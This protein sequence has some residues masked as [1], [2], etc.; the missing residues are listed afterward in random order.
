MAWKEGIE[1]TLSSGFELLAIPY[2]SSWLIWCDRNFDNL[3]LDIE[4]GL[5]YWREI[6]QTVWL[7]LKELTKLITNLKY[8]DIQQHLLTLEAPRVTIK[9]QKVK[10]GK[11]PADGVTECH[12]SSKKLRSVYINVLYIRFTAEIELSLLWN[13]SSIFMI[14]DYIHRLSKYHNCEL[15]WVG[16]IL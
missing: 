3:A 7:T 13:I 10:T 1:T 6:L 2:I 5:I 14:S 16:I 12:R 4:Q 9:N 11:V 15:V 8:I